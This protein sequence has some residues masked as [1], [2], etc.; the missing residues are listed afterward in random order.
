MPRARKFGF[1]SVAVG[2]PVAA[3]VWAADLGPNI[4]MGL[5]G[6]LAL[7]LAA[8]GVVVLVVSYAAGGARRLWGSRSSDPST[9]S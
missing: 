3:I 2:I 4:G 7:A 1:W 9:P 6:L 8:I 5:V